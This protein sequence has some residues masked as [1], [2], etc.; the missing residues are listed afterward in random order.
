[1]RRTPA[2]CGAAASGT[3]LLL[4]LLPCWASALLP[5]PLSCLKALAVPAVAAAAVLAVK[6]TAV[7]TVAPEADASAAGARLLLQ[8]EE[9]AA[10]VA[11][12]P[13]AA[14]LALDGGLLIGFKKRV[15]VE[16]PVGALSN[17]LAVMNREV[18]AQ[19]GWPTAQRLI[20]VH[21]AHTSESTLNQLLLT[22]LPADSEASY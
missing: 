12:A 3:R 21:S 13:T 22:A 5:Q 7:G 8:R 4:L 11:A 16:E 15:I 19:L 9:P 2:Y 1:M 17:L 10:V 20:C 6:E 14:A 18:I